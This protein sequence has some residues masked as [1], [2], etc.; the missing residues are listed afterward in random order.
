M[1]SRAGVDAIFKAVLIDTV[2]CTNGQVQTS[3]FCLREKL[4]K[5]AVHRCE[6]EAILTMCRG[7]CWRST[8]NCKALKVEPGAKQLFNWNNLHLRARQDTALF[9]RTAASD[10]LPEGFVSGDAR[11]DFHCMHDQGNKKEQAYGT[12][13]GI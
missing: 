10:M 9:Q 1:V 8:Y 7:T 13:V 11:H 2:T 3:A 5:L 6:I 4:V 12:A